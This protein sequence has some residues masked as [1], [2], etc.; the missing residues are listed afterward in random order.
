[1]GLNDL[2]STNFWRFVISGGFPAASVARIIF[3]QK[4][5]TSTT[6]LC[7][8]RFSFASLSHIHSVPIYAK[9]S[10]ST[11]AFLATN[12]YGYGLILTKLFLKDY[13]AQNVGSVKRCTLTYGPD[14]KSRGIATIIFAKNGD[15]QKAFETYNGV[16]AD[17]RPMKVCLYGSMVKKSQV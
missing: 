16:L 5:K 12:S 9:I 2:G 17:K 8:G 6:G 13:F 11:D 10:R 3:L 4:T 7:G 1:M 14:G 15:A